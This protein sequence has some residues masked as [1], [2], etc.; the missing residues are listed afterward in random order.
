ME[1]A[2]MSMSEYLSNHCTACGG[3]WTQMLMSGI[4]STFPKLWD[5]MP[6]KTYSF[7]AV[8]AVLAPYVDM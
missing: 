6:D 8:C 1:N 3:N 5:S 7:D 2:K 4:K